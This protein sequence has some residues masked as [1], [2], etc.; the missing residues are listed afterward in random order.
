[1]RE[2]QHGSASLR[3]VALGS[4]PCTVL[5]GDGHVKMADLPSERAANTRLGRAVWGN[6]FV[7]GLGLGLFVEPMLRNPQ[8]RSLT[9]AEIDPDVAA[10]VAPYLPVSP[11]LSLIVGDVLALAAPFQQHGALFDCIHFDIWLGTVVTAHGAW[12]GDY[13]QHLREFDQLRRVWSPL[14]TDDPAAMMTAWIG[15][16]LRALRS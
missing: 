2:A 8:V 12:L 11:R 5:I 4:R 15:G 1:M 7:G 13:A 9:I 6:V 16:R 3:N 14:L 10:L